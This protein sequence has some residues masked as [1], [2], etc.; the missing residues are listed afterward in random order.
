MTDKP[1]SRWADPSET[2]GY[3]FT[4]IAD[5]KRA[6]ADLGNFWFAPDTLA[7]FDSRIGKAL[8]GGRWFVSSE[9]GTDETRRYT[10]RRANADGSISTE[11]SF[12]QYDTSADATR[13]AKRLAK[14]A[15][16]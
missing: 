2:S 4:S 11:G 9:R 13:E 16:L 1:I 15:G 7:A 10:L 5:V 3:W 8:T 6:N 14:E 12:Q